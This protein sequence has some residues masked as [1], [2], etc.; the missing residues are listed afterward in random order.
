MAMVR[1]RLERVRPR[2]FSSSPG[3]G[4]SPVNVSGD[5]FANVELGRAEPRRRV[6]LDVLVVGRGMDRDALKEEEVRHGS[7]FMCMDL[8]CL[9]VSGMCG[10]QRGANLGESAVNERRNPVEGVLRAAVLFARV[11]VRPE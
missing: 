2:S 6:H 1:Q 4:D 11:R 9:P 5:G 8:G 3:S 10:G 7:P